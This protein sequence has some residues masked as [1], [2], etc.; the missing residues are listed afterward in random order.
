[1]K[2]TLQLIWHQLLSLPKRDGLSPASL[3]LNRTLKTRHWPAITSVV[4]VLLIL[5]GLNPNLLWARPASIASHQNPADC[6]DTFD[7]PQGPLIRNS[8]TDIGTNISSTVTGAGILGGERDLQIEMTAG[9]SNNL[10]EAEV[11]GS[12][13]SMDYAPNVEGFTR[14]WWDGPGGGFG[15]PNFTGLGGLDLT[16]RIQDAFLLGIN[17]KDLSP[18]EVRITVFTDM[19][20]AST[21]VVSLPNGIFNPLTVVVPFNA[22]TSTVGGGAD[23]TNVG[24]IL[25]ETT[26]LIPALD[27]E[28]ELLC[29]FPFLPPTPTSIPP[30]PEDDR[31]TDEPVP[32]PAPAPPS[33]GSSASTPQPPEFPTQLPET[34]EPPA[35]P[36]PLFAVILVL[37]GGAAFALKLIKSDKPG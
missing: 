30:T 25:F 29:L 13:L 4:I 18:A 6:V 9:S 20:N 10:L 8:A 7:T 21:F 33:G 32:P 22:P 24:A 16:G 14:I 19:A 23:F 31:A 2:A 5:S 11:I 37:T 36:W 26:P 17:F 34:G 35:Q 15:A 27:M 12:V 28:V 3:F 1:M